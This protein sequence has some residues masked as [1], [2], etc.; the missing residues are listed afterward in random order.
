VI[1]PEALAASPLGKTNFTCA[2]SAWPGFALS[3]NRAPA[4]MSLMPAALSKPAP[5]PGRNDCACS[6]RIG[7]SEN[8]EKRSDV[9]YSPMTYNCW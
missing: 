9:A 5:V 4:R 3:P 8:T 2:V 7:S 6:H 1:G